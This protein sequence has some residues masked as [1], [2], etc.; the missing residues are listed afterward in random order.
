MRY[1][2]HV[3]NDR[4]LS[5][6]NKLVENH[7]QLVLSL[8]S[9]IVQPG[10]HTVQVASSTETQVI[11][12]TLAYLQRFKKTAYACPIDLPHAQYIENIYTCLITSDDP[13]I[14]LEDY[15]IVVLEKELMGLGLE[16]VCSERKQ[17]SVCQLTYRI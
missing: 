14:E 7:E 12:E 15:D 6:K 11:Y 16:R 13:V 5:M 10:Y 9:S 4:G 17:T 3:I 1:A 8:Q 2:P